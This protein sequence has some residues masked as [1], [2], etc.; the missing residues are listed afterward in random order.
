MFMELHI[1]GEFSTGV[2]YF[3]CI[4][5]FCYIIRMNHDEGY[6]FSTS[7]LLHL[8]SNFIPGMSVVIVKDAETVYVGNH[9]SLRLVTHGC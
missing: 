5:M 9:A 7:V 8:L 6:C 4:L 3:W 2:F 1:T